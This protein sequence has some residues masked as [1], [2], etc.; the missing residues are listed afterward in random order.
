MTSSFLKV[1]SLLWLT[2]PLIDDDKGLCVKAVFPTPAVDQQPV[3]TPPSSWT[4]LQHASDLVIWLNIVEFGKQVDTWGILGW[5]DGTPVRTSV[6]TDCHRMS[7]LTL[8]QLGLYRLR[9]SGCTFGSSQ[10]TLQT[11][12]TT[13]HSVFSHLTIQ[14]CHPNTCVDHIE[15]I[16]AFILH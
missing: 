3:K 13:Y 14:Y 5:N 9:L 6:Q 16:N 4:V 10:T 11:I 15:T 8:E 1:V 2:L 12:Q 7:W